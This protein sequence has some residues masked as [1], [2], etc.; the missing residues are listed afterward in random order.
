MINNYKRFILLG[1]PV[2][3]ILTLVFFYLGYSKSKK[4]TEP[5][6]TKPDEAITFFLQEGTEKVIL[7]KDGKLSFISKSLQPVFIIKENKKISDLKIYF[8]DSEKDLI[9]NKF[10]NAIVEQDQGFKIQFPYTLEP[11]SH[12]FII[13]YIKD[14]KEI[15]EEYAFLL[16]LFDDFSVPL[17]KSSLWGLAETGLEYNNWE[18]K[19]G[20]L[21]ANSLPDEAKTSAISSLF[22]IRRFQGDFFVQFDLKPKSNNLSFLTYLLQ[23]K[24]NFVFGNGS[25]RNVV[26]LQKNTRGNFIFEALKTYHIRLIRNK[27]IYKIFVTDKDKFSDSDLLF[28]YEDKEQLKIPF[29]AFGFT[30]WKASGGV[31]IDNFYTS[32][33]DISDIFN[34]Y[35]E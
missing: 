33:E 7:E 31:E 2:L 34:F 3:L 22:F 1:L 28:I 9:T 21:I 6:I 25:N 24:L 29:D 15:T 14:D 20:R 18:I 5:I 27:N 23:R 30:I 13:K 10:S 11:E 12:K 17:Q 32:N 26:L 4:A 16:I 19:E 35:G 8:D